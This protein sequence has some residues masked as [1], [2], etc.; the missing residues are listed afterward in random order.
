MDIKLIS[1]GDRRIIELR[2]RARVQNDLCINSLDLNLF[3]PVLHA[4]QELGP[5]LDLPGPGAGGAQ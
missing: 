1:E 2:E 5:S 3:L 4:A